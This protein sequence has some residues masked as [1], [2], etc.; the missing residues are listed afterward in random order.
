MALPLRRLPVC[1]SVTAA[2][3]HSRGVAGLCGRC[4]ESSP[5]LPMGLRAG[6]AEV[7]CLHSSLPRMRLTVPS[8]AQWHATQE[9]ASA[10]SDLSAQQLHLIFS[11]LCSMSSQSVTAAWV[12]CTVHSAN[13]ADGV[14]KETAGT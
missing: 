1:S 2:V 5:A 6:K 3:G 7:S 14:C 8:G 9:G 12:N 10:R 11:V 4:L 13:V